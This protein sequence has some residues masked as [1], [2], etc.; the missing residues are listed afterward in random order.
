[1]VASSS[2]AEIPQKCLFS[3]G[4]IDNRT[5]RDNFIFWITCSSDYVSSDQDQ[6]YVYL[7]AV[8]S[9][10]A[11]TS[12]LKSRIHEVASAVSDVMFLYFDP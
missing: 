2:V 6:L 10:Q 3:E 7:D 12:L 8:F 9:L 5:I 11:W 4:F 1:M